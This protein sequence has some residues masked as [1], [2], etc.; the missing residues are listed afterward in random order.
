MKMTPEEINE[1]IALSIGWIKEDG[2]WMNGFNFVD[3]P[4]DY[5][6]SLDAC[7]G[8]ETPLLW[9]ESGSTRKYYETLIE[10]VGQPAGYAIACA[11]PIARCEA[12]LS[13]KGLWY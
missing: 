11:S 12:Y 7:S 3:G 1:R 8:F 4:L 10:V 5:C 9:M 2:Q 6:R 13:V